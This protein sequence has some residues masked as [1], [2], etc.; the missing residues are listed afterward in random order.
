MDV[1]SRVVITVGGVGTIAAVSAVAVFLVWVAAPL[2]LPARS[3]EKPSALLGATEPAP[4]RLMLNESRTLGSAMLGG[5]RIIVFD[6]ATGETIETAHEFSRPRLTAWSM[7]ADTAALGY[8]DGTVRFARLGFASNLVG[9]AEVDP[10]L[11]SLAIGATAATEHDGRRGVLSRLS[12]TEFRFDSFELTL[13]DPI[14]VSASSI[15]LIDH[16]ESTTGR[17]F[18]ALTAEGE[19]RIEQVTERTNLLT[20]KVTRTVR[21]GAIPF[22]AAPGRGEPMRVLLSG[23][24]DSVI[25]IW[26]DGRAERYDTRNIEAAALAE[27][28]DLLADDDAQVEAI[29]FL[30]GKAT[31]L[32]GDSRGNVGVWFRARPPGA[33]T[34]DGAVLVRAHLIAG[35]R[36]AVTAL[37]ASSRSRTVAVGHADGRVRLHH[38]TSGK[39]LADLRAGEGAVRLVS[40]AP[41]DDGLVALGDAALHRWILDFRH[42]EVTLATLFAPVWYEGYARPAHVWQSSSGTDDFEAKFGL[43]PLIFGTIKATVYSL[44]FGV[45]LALLAAVYTSEFLHPR[46]K[47]AIKPA[48]EMMASLPSVVLGF[49]AALVIAPFVENV[50]PSVLTLLAALPATFVAGALAWQLL[51]QAAMLRLSRWRFLF[52]LMVAPVGVVL[53]WRLGPTVERLL[54]AGDLR[55][56]LDGQIGSGLGA[57]MLLLAPL[58]AI[59][60]AVFT[61]RIV[62]PWLR[63]RSREWSRRRAAAAD[64][65]KF[66]SAAAGA[67]GAAWLLAFVLTAAGFDP[68]GSFVGTYV[69]RNALIVGFIMGFAIIPI[70]YTIAEDAL[71]TVPEHLR[72]AS[73]GAGATRW[74][75]A[76]RIVLPTAMSGLFSAV[77][78]GLGRAVGET[79]I[80]LM[81]AGNTP[82][83]EWNI[84]NGFRTL[85]ANIAVELPEAV[86]HSTHYRTLFF[87]ALVLFAM[88]FLLNTVAE[89]VR[90]RF[91]RRAYQL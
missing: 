90:L 75:T 9:E 41:K 7:S 73:L 61:S 48:I 29:E 17:T 14:T 2:F 83:M 3:E 43:S 40:L 64:V 5:D 54:F 21:E 13:D 82:V 27:E 81:A 12:E 74:Q 84:F 51:P 19:L 77:M 42:P 57:W 18:V 15:R 30:I 31:M 69:Q 70:I 23:R 33:Q 20:K 55:L 26:K 87:A 71:S 44:L 56:W 78:I 22:A 65:V 68:R 53:A 8:E 58:S 76:V 38:V 80:V 88:T 24:G 86:R 89:M 1:V 37:A 32:V 45:P 34:P 62:N 6:A 50:V 39:L 85:S 36:S 49:F 28:L 66:A 79:M 4:S 67:L 10:R 25:L 47:S 63:P 60:S 35:R 11:R 16:I 91:R 59:L 52:I 72:A 46:A